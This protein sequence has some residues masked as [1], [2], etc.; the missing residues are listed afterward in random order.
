M[1]LVRMA[2][3]SALIAKGVGLSSAE[4]DAIELAAPMHDIGKIGIP[5]RILQNPGRLDGDDLRV[6]QSHA[7]IGYDMLKDSSSGYLQ[8]AA[9]IALGHHEKY[10][11]S[12]YPTGLQRRA[13]PARSA[14]RRD[15]GRLR[16]ADLG[17]TLQAGVAGRR[18]PGVHG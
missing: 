5:D 8:M 10:D 4:Q 15:R 12:G 11:G 16:R 18:S 6:M 7:R 17:A 2:K 9:V 3:Y 14:H 1:H 13:H